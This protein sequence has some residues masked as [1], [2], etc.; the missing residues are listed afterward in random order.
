MRVCEISDNLTS[1]GLF[2]PSTNDR[3]LSEKCTLGLTALLTMA[4]ILLIVADMV[5]KSNTDH[6]PL[7]GTIEY[8]PYY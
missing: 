3:E 1:A 5:P 7:L 8:S 4:V 2:T 6:F